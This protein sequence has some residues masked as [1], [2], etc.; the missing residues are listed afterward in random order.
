[1]VEK[2]G[3]DG[4]TMWS[5]VKTLQTV[6]VSVTCWVVRRALPFDPRWWTFKSAIMCRGGLRAEWAG[7]SPLL[8]QF[9]HLFVPTHLDVRGKLDP[10]D[11][12]VFTV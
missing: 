4:A 5:N 8:C 3:I 6:G 2:R 7:V 10:F 11:S 9:V 12:T 1:M